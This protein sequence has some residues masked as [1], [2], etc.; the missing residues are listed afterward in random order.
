[1]QDALDNILQTQKITTVIIAH[2]LST[3]RNADVINVIH[4][5]EVV[6]SGS[7]A[8]LMEREEYYYRLVQKQD[9]STSSTQS[10]RSTSATDIV[11][12]N[13]ASDITSDKMYLDASTGVEHIEFEDVRF[14]YPTRPKKM[15]FDG[16]NF[17][18]H[19]G[20]TVALVGPSGQGKSSTVSLI[21]RFYDPC[22]G[23][24]K[25][26]GHDLKTLNVQW[27]RD[28]IGYVGQ[29]PTLFQDTIGRN[30]GYGFPGATQFQIEEAAKL[31]NAHDFISGFPEGYNTPV[32]QRGS[33]LSGG[34]KQVREIASTVSYDLNLKYLS[35]LCSGLLSLGK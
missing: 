13:A 19:Q 25:Y 3:I 23:V 16:F 15:I 11:G 34:Q 17:K 10:S 35:R 1:M 14:A 8:D 7:H 12:L 27:Y 21:E 4:E 31:A 20:Q 33:Q 32:G 2:R 26:L 5:G 28:Q 24:V 6:E 29:E 9:G 30:I 18:I 22:A